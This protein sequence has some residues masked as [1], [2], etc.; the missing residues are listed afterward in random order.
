M[1]VVMESLTLEELKAAGEAPEWL[2]DEGFQTLRKGYLLPG[3]SPRAMYRRVSNSAARYLGRPELADRFYELIDN[4]W[5]CPATPVASNAGTLR[6]LPISCYGMT[7][8]DSLDGIYMSYHETAMLTKG[9]GGIGKYWGSIRGKGS[10]ISGGGVS[11]GIVP[12]LKVEEATLQSTAQAGVRRGS[13]AQYLDIESPD[14][15]EFIELRRN[16]GD[17]SRRCLSNNFHH[18]VCI[19]DD[20]MQRCMNGEKKAQ[21]LWIKILTARLETGEPYLMFKDTA[22]RAAPLCYKANRLDIPT[23]QLCNE[24]YLHTDEDHTFVCC[25]SSMN[26]ARWDEWKDTDAVELAIWFLDGIM[27]EFIDKAKELKGFERAVRFARK[28]RALGLGVLGWHTLL[29]SKMI[30]FESFEAMQLNAEIFRTMDSRSLAA[31]K[32]LAAVFGEVE[33]TTGFGVRNTHR[34]AVAP[35][36]SNSLISGG[37]SQG[38]EPLIANYYAQ[39]GAKGTFIRKNRSLQALLEQKGKDTFDTWEQI[40][41]DGGS[42]RNLPFLSADEKEV[43]ATAR[44][45]NQF[46]VVKQAAQRQQWID[47]GQSVNLFFQTGTDL[48]TTS[49]KRLGAYIHEVHLEAYTSGLK[50]LYYLRPTSVLQGDQI[51][52]EGSECKSCEA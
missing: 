6:G 17:I 15:D 49:R 45:I 7:V 8:P 10:A 48:D 22:N 40:N 31:S 18:A 26:L 37:V 52:R 30:P 47:Q 16:T 44:E 12:W 42:V 46:A 9:G 41:K 13:G 24:I 35:T 43:F 11:D 21:D 14:I 3:E 5:L 20:F 34:M 2:N 33:W 29:Q 23:S 1:A 51:Y 25:L 50:G 28:G 19:T 36:V 32:E 27:E 4:N 38:I 39:K